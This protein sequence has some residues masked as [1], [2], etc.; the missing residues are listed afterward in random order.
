MTSAIE[1]SDIPRR[2]GMA[3]KALILTSGVLLSTLA[4]A[5]LYLFI[6]SLHAYGLKG[7]MAI[8]D[9]YANGL[10]YCL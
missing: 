1:T 2:H 10:T 7:T 6:G 3:R 8:F 5:G 9:M 4:I